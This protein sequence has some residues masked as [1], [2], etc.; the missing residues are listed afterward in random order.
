MRCPHC[1]QK[2]RNNGHRSDGDLWSQM[3]LGLAT[4]LAIMAVVFVIIPLL[5]SG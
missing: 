5:F 2:Y 1:G 3:L 4:A